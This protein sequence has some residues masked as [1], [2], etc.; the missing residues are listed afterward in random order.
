M[1]VIGIVYL[2]IPKNTDLP[3]TLTNPITL[4]ML[5]PRCLL[6]GSVY[7][8]RWVLSVSVAVGGGNLKVGRS[9]TGTQLDWVPNVPMAPTVGSRPQL[10]MRTQ[11]LTTKRSPRVAAEGPA[12]N[13]A[14]KLCCSCAIQS[15]L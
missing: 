15:K 10:W 1:D 7:V 14:S 2:R 8:V 5:L 3:L 11:P 9:E 6:T 4:N 13:E 12:Q